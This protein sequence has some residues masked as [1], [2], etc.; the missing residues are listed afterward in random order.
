M[1]SAAV[2]W[3]AALALASLG[4]GVGALV[5]RSVEADL[6]RS[7]MGGYT[8]EGSHT[9]CNDPDR[10]KD[11]VT[12]AFVH[13]ATPELVEHHA[14]EHGYTNVEDPPDPE[15]RFYDHGLCEYEQVDAA[16]PG[17]HRFHMR[18]RTGAD[19]DVAWGTFSVGAVHRDQAAGPGVPSVSCRP[20]T[21]K[22]TMFLRTTRVG[23]T[24]AL[25]QAR[26]TS[27]NGG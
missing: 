27:L 15:Q 25:L 24:A 14:V 11:P 1:Q 20:G 4:A 9:T 10:W 22:D 19:T 13:G 12:V 6:S 2:R 16:T 5:A 3:L 17:D 18:A 23:A 7:D 26:L 21:L 8:Y